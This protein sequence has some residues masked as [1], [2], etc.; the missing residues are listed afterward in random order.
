MKYTVELRG[1]SFTARHAVAFSQDVDNPDGQWYCED[2]HSHEFHVSAKISGPVDDTGCVVDF[3]DADAALKD[4]VAKL[5]GATILSAP[6]FAIFHDKAGDEIVLRYEDKSSQR[7]AK[8]PAKD[9]VW[10]R[11]FNS[12][13]EYVA[14]E[15][16]RAWLERLEFYPSENSRY[17]ASLTLEEETN[18][19]VEVEMDVDEVAKWKDEVE[20]WKTKRHD[21]ETAT[22]FTWRRPDA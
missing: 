1:Y 17:S 14:G 20:E 6:S 11:R 5:D 9:V 8:V 21:S 13:T 22:R 12:T 18:R 15:L 4:V 19:F 10:L 16:L 7:V 3:R 2:L